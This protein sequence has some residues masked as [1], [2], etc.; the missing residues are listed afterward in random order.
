MT[1]SSDSEMAMALMSWDHAIG[2]E[3]ERILT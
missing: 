3:S 1:E 2:R